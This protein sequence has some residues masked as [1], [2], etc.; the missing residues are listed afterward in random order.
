MPIINGVYRPDFEANTQPVPWI[1]MGDDQ[2]Q[3][4]DVGPMAGAFK[5]RFMNQPAASPA[6]HPGMGAPPIS[7]HEAP[8]G[9]AKPGGFKSL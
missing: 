1:P 8:G 3:G 4:I 6:G 9:S 7:P 5:K 2:D